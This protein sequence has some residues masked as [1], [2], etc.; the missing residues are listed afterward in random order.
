MTS[1]PRGAWGEEPNHLSLPYSLVPRAMWESWLVT[2]CLPCTLMPRDRTAHQGRGCSHLREGVGAILITEAPL[3]L[4]AGVG[5]HGHHVL[6]SGAGELVGGWWFRQAAQHSL[7]G[8][9]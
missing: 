2:L 6:G 9:P 7:L 1:P 5:Q 4:L 8:T 3:E